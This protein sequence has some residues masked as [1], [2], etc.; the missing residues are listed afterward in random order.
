M[1]ANIDEFDEFDQID[2]FGQSCRTEWVTEHEG[3][4]NEVTRR[5]TVYPDGTEYNH[6]YRSGGTWVDGWWTGGCDK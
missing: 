2:A 6:G 1:V 4:R 3:T 5:V